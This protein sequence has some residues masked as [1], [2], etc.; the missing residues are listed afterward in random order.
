MLFYK[1]IVILLVI[2][3]FA[4]GITLVMCNYASKQ[5]QDTIMWGL[6]F[7]PF[8]VFLFIGIYSG[9]EHG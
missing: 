7:V 9:V 6:F 8:I 1:S 5:L 4:T 3:G 2:I